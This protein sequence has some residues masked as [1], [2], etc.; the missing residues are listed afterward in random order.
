MQQRE[1]NSR[2][3]QKEAIRLP[4]QPLLLVPGN[5]YYSSCS[6]FSTLTKKV[7]CSGRKRAK[8]GRKFGASFWRNIFFGVAPLLSTRPPT[9]HQPPTTNRPPTTTNKKSGPPLDRLS[10]PRWSGGGYAHANTFYT[11]L[12]MVNLW[13][14][15][16]SRSAKVGQ[17]RCMYGVYHLVAQRMLFKMR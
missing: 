14:K 7:D 16:W 9:N 17:K 11:H 13:S 12:S 3:S 5:S 1:S 6:S 2:P 8:K 4:A 10:R 15:I